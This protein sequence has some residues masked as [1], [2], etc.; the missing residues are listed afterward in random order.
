[1]SD[2]IYTFTPGE[3]YTTVD[4]NR[5]RADYFSE[6]V[7]KATFLPVMVNYVY[8]N[9]ISTNGQNIIPIPNGTYP[10]SVAVD[11]NVPPPTRTAYTVSNSI[12]S[13]G[14]TII[15]IPS[16]VYPET[17]ELNVNVPVPETLATYRYTNT[18][19]TNAYG[20]YSKVITVPDGKYANKIYFQINVP[21]QVPVIQ[22]IVLENTSNNVRIFNMDDIETRNGIFNF[23]NENYPN[24]TFF[25]KKY[26]FIEFYTNNYNM[27]ICEVQ[28]LYSPISLPTKGVTSYYCLIE[29]ANGG[30]S[31]GTDLMMYFKDEDERNLYLHHLQLQPNN[32]NWEQLFQL[33][34]KVIK[35]MY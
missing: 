30:V 19:T 33:S 32:S 13:N 10:S 20:D 15:N 1:M 16:G 8:P 5:V 29:I 28:Y 7:I 26:L 34:N 23:D 25:L 3:Y 4:G 12:V 2:G 11:I 17:V 22:Y 6:V 27:V 14:N 18:F 24:S 9:V 35:Y 31:F 21:D